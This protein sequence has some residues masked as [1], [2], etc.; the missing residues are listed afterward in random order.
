MSQ[1][2]CV[3]TLRYVSQLVVNGFQMIFFFPKA[4]KTKLDSA[5][6]QLGEKMVSNK[7]QN[8]GESGMLWIQF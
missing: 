7:H 6:R 5:K 3:K 4:F 1:M 8:L 2:A